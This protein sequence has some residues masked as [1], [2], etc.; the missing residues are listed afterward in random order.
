VLVVVMS[1]ATIGA[2][3]LMRSLPVIAAGGH[4]IH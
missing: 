2:F 1:G 4:S 3:E